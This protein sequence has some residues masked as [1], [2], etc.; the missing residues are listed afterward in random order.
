MSKRRVPTEVSAYPASASR[1]RFV[2][3][4]T[5]EHHVLRG[6]APTDPGAVFGDEPPAT[7]VHL[8]R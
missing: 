3:A 2:S 7:M 4:D 1:R 8:I 5:G 6:L